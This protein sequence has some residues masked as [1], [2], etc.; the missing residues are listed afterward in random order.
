MLEKD[1]RTSQN[2]YDKIYLDNNNIFD[3][4]P[5]DTN[6]NTDINVMKNE[7]NKVNVIN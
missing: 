6:L 1:F 7:S 2:K 5:S 4:K 3:Y